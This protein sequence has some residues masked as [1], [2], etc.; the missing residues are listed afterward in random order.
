ML[1]FSRLRI[2]GFKSFV[3]PVDLLIEPG[4]TGVVGPN[5]CGKS[6]LVEA[7]R[8]VMG[9]ASARQM[10]GG[11]MDDV[12]FAGSAGRPGRQLAEVSVDLDNAAGDA[13]P[14]WHTADTLAVTRRIE[15]G[16]GSSYR[17][18]GREVRA[19]DVQLL[20]A[21]AATGARST[22][23]VSQGQVGAIIAA[24][25]RERRLILEEAA[26]IT[27]LHARR[28][29]A[30]L[31]LRAAAAN[32]ERVDDVLAALDTQLRHL[33]KQSRQAARYR[34]VSEDIRRTEALVFAL[35]WRAAAADAA[36]AAEA[37]RAAEAVVAERTVGATAAASRR[38]EAAACLPALR[39]AETAAVAEMQ[40]LKAGIETLDAEDRRIRTDRAAADSRLD[41]A[42]AD[43]K[44]ERA[45]AE[46]AAGALSQLAAERQQL[47]ARRGDDERAR[48][49]AADRLAEIDAAVEKREADVV[50]RTREVAAL[51]AERT[52]LDRRRADLAERRRR[53]DQRRAD[54]GGQ[55]RALLDD[56]AA[57]GD[58][59]A[60]TAAAASAAAALDAARHEADAA[61]THRTETTERAAAA[62]ADRLAAD[63]ET[64]RWQA[65]AEALAA[66]LDDGGRGDGPPIVD[67]VSVPADLAAA[68]AAALG[69]DLLATEAPTGAAIWRTLDPVA[70]PPTLPNDATPLSH[71]VSAPP[72]LA[73]R[74]QQIGL[75]AD[76]ATGDR[77]QPDLRP[78]QRLVT[79]SGGLWRWDGF[80]ASPAVSA[81][82]AR[83][84]QRTRLGEVTERLAECRV[85]AAAAAER[86]AALTSAADAA[87]AADRAARDRL[88]ALRTAAETA[89]RAG[90]EARRRLAHVEARR[91][92]LDETVVTLDA[93]I[94]E[95][96][97]TLQAAEAERAALP[98]ASAKRAE[99]AEANAALTA[100]RAEQR[101]RRAAVDALDREI[102]GR[103][104][105][106]D[107]IHEEL[108][109]WT[110]RRDAAHRQI[111]ALDERRAAAAAE[112]AQLADRPA[113][114]AAER[115]ALLD[116]SVA[117]EQ[118]RRECGDRLAAAESALSEADRAA[119]AAD[120]ALA[121]AREALVRAEGGAERSAAALVDIERRIVDVLDLTPDALTEAA[122]LTTPGVDAS[123]PDLQTNER[124]LETLRRE[125]EAIGPVNLCAERE[126]ADLDEQRTALDR[127]KQDLEQAIVKLRQGVAELTREGRK[128]LL[129]SFADVDRHFRELFVRLFDG[130][131][132]HLALTESE[133]PLDAG[134]EIMASPPGK[135]LQALSLL[136]GGEQALA[137][138]ALVFAVFRSNPAP[139]CVL[140][141]VDA[142]LDDANVDRFCVLLDEMAA[143]GGTRFLVITHHRMTMARMHRL[144]G[145]TMS[146][147]GVSQLVSV[148]LQGA[149]ALRRTA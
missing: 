15:R 23:L 85:A 24:R 143:A 146:E 126:A 116:A 12:I 144:F 31:R 22:A 5:G 27:G 118:R 48:T 17:V 74:L 68:L 135:K 67:A 101:G 79:V 32:L 72:A 122:G 52:A 106:R 111:A 129:A 9:E 62:R 69:D 19:R 47:E 56:R 89:E 93:D 140:D 103:R 44:R 16:R 128:R 33:K 80:S 1:G 26:G 137:T 131:H 64:A 58:L 121:T 81:P 115:V 70:D 82:V 13:P 51:D 108:A 136:S 147:R 130:G 92:T 46:E 11:E 2:A 10:R 37:L 83:L 78:G 96:A 141:E 34:V 35:A 76:A 119:R 21:D 14:P 3:D 8:W 105:R 7:L 20:F 75:V 66:V 30:E 109:A 38:T 99:L 86:A 142:P 65:E 42:A 123:A 90:A 110:V 43:L 50:A 112:I 148:D 149:E 55:R 39:E 54:L 25:P 18:N 117:A 139:I 53:L 97:A 94:A 59:D 36:A 6:N 71:A 98:D 40:R 95:T 73:R 87:L 28:H 138:L 104:R 107:R 125:R 133:D 127:E 120:A 29:E 102:A 124:R 45:L 100:E 134:L 132:A 49:T 114:L 77:L 41:Q 88:R 57:L 60:L 91:A 84:R 61:E 113:D 145:V 63:A 4:L